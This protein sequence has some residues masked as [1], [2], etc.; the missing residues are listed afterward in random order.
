MALPKYKFKCWCE[1][2]ASGIVFPPDQRT[3][4]RELMEHMEDHYDALREEGFADEIAQQL[5]VEA[6][7]DPWPIAKDLAA[8]HKPFWGY[9]L[10]ATRVILV[11]ALIVT[12]I[13]FV[14]YAWETD[15]SIH[16]LPDWEVFDKASYGGDTGRTLLHLWSPGI[17]QRSDG[18]TFKLTNAAWWYNEEYDNSCFY[19]NMEEFHPLPWAE[20]EAAG[21][22]F[23]AEDNLGNVYECSMEHRPN[24]ETPA[25]L[26]WGNMSNPFT[27]TYE[28]WINDDV[29]QEVEWLAIRYTRDGRDLAF[30]I[31]LTGGDGA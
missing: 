12:L 22:W 20:H 17:I 11:I 24:E 28:M 7:G 5:T 16:M 9:F 2:A 8:I 19:L 30:T 23:W 14:K 25:L 6:M 3:V 29:P 18:Y 31:D 4:Y 21:V 27:C 1:K 13:P 10:R 15:Y 26:T